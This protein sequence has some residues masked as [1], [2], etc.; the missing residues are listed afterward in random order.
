M[1]ED[2]ADGIGTPVDR[3]SQRSRL[4]FK[5]QSAPALRFLSR[6]SGP[7]FGSIVRS[8]KLWIIVSRVWTAGPRRCLLR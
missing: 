2:P 4:K 3:N 6:S 5:R 1:G 7:A 8:D